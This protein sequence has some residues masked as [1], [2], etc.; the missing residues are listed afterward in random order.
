MAGSSCRPRCSAA[1]VSSAS[2]ERIDRDGRVIVPLADGAARQAAERLVEEAGVE[3]LTVSTLWS[4][5]NPDHELRAL[6][7]VRTRYPDLIV[8]SGVELQPAIREYER[9]TFALLNAYVARSLNGVDA[10]A[11][12]LARLGLRVPLLLVHSGGGSMT[13]SEARRLPI[14]LAASGPAAGVAASSL[15]ATAAGIE[16]AITCDVGGTSYDVALVVDGQPERRTRG[17]IMGIW[18]SVAT[19]DVKSLGAGGGSLAWID[20]RGLLRVGPRSAGAVPG[21]VCYG[22]GGTQPT[23]T[24]ALLVLGYLDG[25]HFLGGRMRLDYA[26]AFEAC[27]QLGA[28]LGLPAVDCAW[29]IREIALAEMVKA[30]RSLLSTRGLDAR[31]FTLLTYGGCGPLFTTGVAQSIGAPRLVVP[32]LASV[33]SAFGA[34]ASDIRRE[35]SVPLSASLP[36][37]PQLFEETMASLDAE[38][39][40]ELDADGVAEPQRS[41]SFEVDLRF[42]RQ[43][44]EL[45]IPIQSV[46][47]RRR[48]RATGRCLPR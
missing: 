15:V 41:V 42:V 3:A 8:T 45:T 25:E 33:L 37:A 36:C 22:R 18:T 16:R 20:S 21:P 4:F 28:A 6:H 10:L 5:K 35:R 13:T 31:E 9:T 11:S 1:N 26:A 29:G 24:D 34:A 14:R 44:W 46:S 2:T 40:K 32:A 48:Y 12:Q 19:V 47:N 27:E 39:S 38:L 7:E 17:D 30:T 23:V 43:R